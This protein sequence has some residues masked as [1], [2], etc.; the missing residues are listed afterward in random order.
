VCV[1][2]YELLGAL[3]LDVADEVNDL[4]QEEAE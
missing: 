2:L 1:Y 4:L 3:P